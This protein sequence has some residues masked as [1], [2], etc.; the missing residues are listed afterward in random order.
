MNKLTGLASK[1]FTS[2]RTASR[3]RSGSSE[4]AGACTGTP[5]RR[6]TK[7]ASSLPR[8]VSRIAPFPAFMD[9]RLVRE[10]LVGE[11]EA[12]DHVAHQRAREVQLGLRAHLVDRLGQE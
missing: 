1:P 7:S 6:A 2:E 4:S 12:V 11:H 3:S 8:R 9:A 5:P 10:A